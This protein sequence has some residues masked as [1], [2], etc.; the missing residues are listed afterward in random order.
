VAVNI[1]YYEGALLETTRIYECLSL[2]IPVVSETSS[3]IGEHTA[4]ANLVD[5]VNIGDESALIS[6]IARVL[7]NSPEVKHNLL[8]AGQ[9]HFRFMLYRVMLAMKQIDFD[10]FLRITSGYKINSD[11]VCLSLPETV[12]RRALFRD[13]QMIGATI[14]DGIRFSPGWIGCALSYKYICQD[15]IASEKSRLLICEDDVILPEG[16]GRRIKIVEEYLNTHARDWDIFSGLIA[17]LN[18]DARVE[19]VEYLHGETFIT[20]NKMT[21]TVFN[22]YN[23]RAIRLISEWDQKN[24]DPAT[25]TIDRYLENSPDLKVITT[26]PF[27]AGHHEDM[28]S[29]LWGFN[30][31]RY[32][33]MISESEELLKK[34]V[35]EF[36]TTTVALN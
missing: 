7:E 8:L 25:N 28:N 16:S 21:S 9:E 12:A 13:T 24:I 5:F 30:N 32:N 31:S 11:V 6:A 20:L 35:D 33:K 2:G 4:L 15:A 26:L 23:K 3:D 22:Y 18:P 10:C 27:L 19:S 29:S 17:H 36:L 34:K 14:F 1:H